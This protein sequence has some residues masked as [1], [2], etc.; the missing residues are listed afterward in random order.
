MKS[1]EKAQIKQ[2]QN[3][4]SDM[5]RIQQSGMHSVNMPSPNFDNCKDSLMQLDVRP[6]F[7]PV[8]SGGCQAAGL[9]DCHATGQCT[10]LRSVCERKYHGP[11]LPYSLT[12]RSTHA[13]RIVFKE[14]PVFLCLSSIDELSET[15]KKGEHLRPRFRKQN[16]ERHRNYKGGK[17]Q[18]KS[19]K[20]LDSNLPPRRA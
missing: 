1:L 20:I 15:R 4:C 19:V 17:I 3:T 9:T 13:P 18:V 5:I 2:M 11:L 16:L 8:K 14:L 10:G 7:Q 12:L 6:P